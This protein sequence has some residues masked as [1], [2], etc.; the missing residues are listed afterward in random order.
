MPL[1]LSDTVKT[2]TFQLLFLMKIAA[3]IVLY[4]IY[5]R[6]YPDREHADIFKYYDDSAII[7]NTAFSHPL[8]FI[9][10][11]T[12]ITANAPDL[13][14]YYDSMHNWFNSEMIFNDSRT[15]IRL[16]TIFRFFSFGTYFPHAIIM[17]FLSMMGLTGLF[18]IFNS[19]LPRREFLMIILVYLMPS[20][21]LWSSGMIK[22]AF[23]IFSIGM[24]LYLIHI[25][26]R[27][28]H[29]NFLR[30]LG[31]IFFSFSLL[32]IKSYVF[33][34]VIPGVLTWII[35]EKWKLSKGVK[36]LIIHG[37][38]LVLL[39]NVAFTFAHKN[40]P[41][42]LSAKQNEFYKVAIV[43]QAN[44]LIKLNSLEGTTSSLLKNSP[45]AFSVTFLRPYLG[46]SKSPLIVIASIE[47]TLIVIFSLLC[48]FGMRKKSIS[49][50]KPLFYLAIYFSIIIFVLI[51]LVTP[52]LGAIVRY[53]V[54]ALSFFLFAVFTLSES[55]WT[56]YC[57]LKI[58]K[59][60]FYK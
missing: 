26:L 52:I 27:D 2:R 32:C 28:Q 48:I 3:A 41:E 24:L 53:K 18:R 8:D 1:F 5:T 17:C 49:N 9:R 45:Q 38:Y 13:W 51:G 22:E 42:L 57:P 4:L 59:F 30:V 39:F 19:V 14:N 31:I 40:V 36:A 23:L 20:T 60:L 6:F 15:M 37:I 25:Y 44:S 34:A 58:K 54:P 12:G 16:N 50:P 11:L 35:C 56:T 10:M 47:N 55:K 46:E 33:F 21:L 29:L 43:Q 7:Y